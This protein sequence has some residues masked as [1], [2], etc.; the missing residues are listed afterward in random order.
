MLSRSLGLSLMLLAWAPAAQAAWQSAAPAY[1]PP[2]VPRCVDVVAHYG[3]R[4]IWVGHFAGKYATGA[5]GGTA[6]Y[7]A[8]GCFL[9]EAQCRRWLNQNLSF[10]GHPL[11][12]MSCRPAAGRAVY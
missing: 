11:L 12:T 1:P 7:G 10:A 3:E 6:S 4:G 9:S 5:P 2:P 8:V